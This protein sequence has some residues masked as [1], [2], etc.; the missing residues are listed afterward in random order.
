MATSSTKLYSRE[1][2]TSP[3]EALYRLTTVGSPVRGVY[4]ADIVAQHGLRVNLPLRSYKPSIEVWETE[5]GEWWQDEVARDL[6]TEQYS[7]AC[8]AFEHNTK[9]LANSRTTFNIA[10]AIAQQLWVP[11]RRSQHLGKLF[12]D[13]VAQFAA[14]ISEFLQLTNFPLADNFSC[15]SAEQ[16]P[17]ISCL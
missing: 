13:L 8:Y 10:R 11:V 17:M 2:I 9:S 5:E 3:P 14:D 12:Y 15:E 7:I 4:G 6:S 16:G 1:V